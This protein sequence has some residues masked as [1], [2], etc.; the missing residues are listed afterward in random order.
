MS[1]LQNLLDSDF[2]DKDSVVSVWSKDFYDEVKEFVER[3]EVRVET[4]YNSVY[5]NLK[6]VALPLP[7]DCDEYRKSF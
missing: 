6:P 7:L 4:M 1:D 3:H 5:K 2:K